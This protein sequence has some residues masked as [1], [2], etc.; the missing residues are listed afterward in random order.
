MVGLL[1]HPF[2]DFSFVNLVSTLVRKM[3]YI[4]IFLLFISGCASW[5][6]RDKILAG[7]STAATITDAYTTIKMLDNPNNYERNPILGEHPSNSTVIVYL[8]L[9]QIITL[10]IAHAF[11]KIRPYLLIGKAIVNTT[12]TINNKQLDWSKDATR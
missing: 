3:R 10:S 7:W 8:G 4:L 5:S 12:C 2:Q 1:D 6:T 9:S 11:P